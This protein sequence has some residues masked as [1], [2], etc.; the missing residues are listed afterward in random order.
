MRGPL[1]LFSTPDAGT[2]ETP[3]ITRAQLLAARRRGPDLWHAD[4]ARG[5]LRLVP[6]T[7]IESEPYS[8]YL[9]V[10]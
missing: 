6:F 5:A 9:R 2:G 8:T 3:S 7:A 1:V 4:T 10:T